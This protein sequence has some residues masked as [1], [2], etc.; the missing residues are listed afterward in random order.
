MF[1]KGDDV[2]VRFAGR[3]HVGKV[4]SE[5]NGWILC[6]IHID[7]LWNYGSLNDRLG[8]ISIVCVRAVFVKKCQST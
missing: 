4:I 6:R 1:S 8:E 2:V 3:D 5:Q 7:P